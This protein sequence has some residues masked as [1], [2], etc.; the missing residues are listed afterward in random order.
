MTTQPVSAPDGAS[1]PW[2]AKTMSYGMKL[3]IM[4]VFVLALIIAIGSIFILIG[5]TMSIAGGSTRP[6]GS[7]VGDLLP[8]WITLAVLVASGAGV[9]VLWPLVRRP[10]SFRPSYG[11]LPANVAEQPFEVRFRKP[12]FA[13]SFSGKGTLRFDA[14]HVALDGTL[15]PNAWLQIGFIVLLTVLPLVLFGIGLGVIPA[16]LIGALIGRKKMSMAMPYAQLRDVALNGC[17]LSFR[18]DGDVPNTVTLYISQIDG[19]RLYRE[20][21]LRFPAALRGWTI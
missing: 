18:R 16:L 1:P 6:T 2:Q 10:T 4:L 12:L 19:E 13:R 14:E 7:M 5:I 3:L 9:V 11:Q 8:L 17:Q 20:V 21:A 15:G